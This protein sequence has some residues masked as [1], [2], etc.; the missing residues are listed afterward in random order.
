MR[1]HT[2]TREYNTKCSKTV[3]SIKTKSNKAIRTSRTP[4]TLIDTMNSSSQN[5]I[6]HGDP[7]ADTSRHGK[8][9]PQALTPG[10]PVQQDRIWPQLLDEYLTRIIF[11]V[12]ETDTRAHGTSS[13]PPNT[14]E[15][16]PA[17]RVCANTH[18]QGSHNVSPV[19]GDTPQHFNV[20]PQSITPTH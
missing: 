18:Q 13:L 15:H 4:N 3:Q 1:S 2:P 10:F 12:C 19:N 6:V 5:P 16:A 14:T 11:A 8:S 17:A 9:T 20:Y 7:T